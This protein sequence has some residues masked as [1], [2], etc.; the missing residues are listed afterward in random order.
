M[1]NGN[2]LVEDI[3]CK[4]DLDAMIKGNEDRAEVLYTLTKAPAEWT[5][6]RGRINDELVKQHC[7][8]DDKTMVLVCG[9]EPL[10]KSVHVALK[11][12]G[13]ADDQIMFF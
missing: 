1:L 8:R 10:E 13:W 7:K 9:P 2:R 4:E 3:L 5:G 11:D 6:L 12:Q